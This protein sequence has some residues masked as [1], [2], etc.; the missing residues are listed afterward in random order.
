MIERTNARRRRPTTGLPLRL[1]E[2]RLAMPGVIGVSAAWDGVVCCV[3]VGRDAG[4]P[5]FQPLDEWKHDVALVDARALGCEVRAAAGLRLPEDELV[6]MEA[7]DREMGAS[8]CHGWV[9]AAERDPL[10]IA[11]RA[12]L[13][14]LT[15]TQQAAL[16]A[17]GVPFWVAGYTRHS[18]TLWLHRVTGAHAA[19]APPMLRDDPRHVNRWLGQEPRDAVFRARWADRVLQA[20]S[21]GDVTL[22]GLLLYARRRSVRGERRSPPADV[23]RRRAR[24]GLVAAQRIVAGQ[25]VV[26]VPLH[27]R[28]RRVSLPAF[29]IQ[30]ATEDPFGPGSDPPGAAA[31]PVTI[32]SGERLGARPVGRVSRLTPS[33]N[34]RGAAKKTRYARAFKI[35]QPLTRSRHEQAQRFE[36]LACRSFGSGRIGGH[37]DSPEL[38]RQRTHERLCLRAG[39]GRGSRR[40]RI[41]RA[42]I[43]LRI[44][45]G[46]RSEVHLHSRRPSRPAPTA[47][48]RVRRGLFTWSPISRVGSC[49]STRS[50][51]PRVLA[52][53]AICQRAGSPSSP[54]GSSGPVDGE[55]RLLP[56][57]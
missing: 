3:G 35:A 5:G 12:H 33:R 10:A 55:R 14:P 41:S 46:R 54:P 28:A 6:E 49:R 16:V 7:V 39:N 2:A 17:R 1:E 18:S 13:L 21:D 38:R 22:D 40:V 31:A 15:S 37:L 50:G 43:F 30:V 48:S 9:S 23:R 29:S 52:S 8:G 47:T 4:F 57:K 27:G 56:K 26:D 44:R 53:R 42:A 19:R 24:A 45:N 36:A 11:S 34:Q 51:V 32:H 20:L 25:E